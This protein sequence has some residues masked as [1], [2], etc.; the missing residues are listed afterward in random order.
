MVDGAATRVPDREAV[1]FR[2]QRVTYRDLKRRADDFA[3]GLLAIG[4]GPGDHVVLWMPNSVEWAV[5]N[6]GIAKI[7]AVTVTCNSRYKAIEVDYVLRQSDARALIMV[8][9]F[10]AAAIDYLA[11]LQQLCP[12]GDRSA[13]PKLR[14]VIVRGGQ[15]PAGAVSFRSEEHTSE[16][17]SLRH[18]VC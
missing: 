4:L 17:Q 3:R 16:L 7:G 13:F 2:G 6:L 8:D 14:H 5:A 1:V 11:I 12:D 15:R 9:R 10:D 18:L